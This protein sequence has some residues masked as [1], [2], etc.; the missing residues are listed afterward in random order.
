MHYDGSFENNYMLQSLLNEARIKKKRKKREFCFASIDISTAFGSITILLK[1]LKTNGAGD[2]IV[3][4]AA[5]LLENTSTL[6]STAVGTSEPH[7]MK[8]GVRQGDP[9]S[10][11]FFKIAIDSIL[12]M[13]KKSALCLQMTFCK[14]H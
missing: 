14:S 6:L 10:G 3:S 9:I 2:K 8:K 1:A 11:F 12:K 5:V 13:L 7:P 4:T